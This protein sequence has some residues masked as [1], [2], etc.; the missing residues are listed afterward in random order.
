MVYQTSTC[1]QETFLLENLELG[2]FKV[3]LWLNLILT[4]LDEVCSE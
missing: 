1:I 3:F 4:F 2:I